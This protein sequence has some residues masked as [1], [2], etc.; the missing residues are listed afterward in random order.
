MVSG[1]AH[2]AFIAQFELPY[3]L[4]ILRNRKLRFF[5]ER[6]IILFFNIAYVWPLSNI[7]LMHIYAFMKIEAFLLDAITSLHALHLFRNLCC[8]KEWVYYLITLLQKTIRT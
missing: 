7:L 3:N 1:V 8:A 4:R 5:Y 2:G 6:E